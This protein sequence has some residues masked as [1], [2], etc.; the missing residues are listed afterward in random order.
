MPLINQC[1]T[2]WSHDVRKIIFKNVPWDFC[3]LLLCVF[4]S[5][6]FSQ[7]SQGSWFLT[8]SG[9]QPTEGKREKKFYQPKLLPA[10]VNHRSCVMGTHT[11]AGWLRSLT[12]P[13]ATTTTTGSQAESRVSHNDLLNLENCSRH[14]LT[15][16]FHYLASWLPLQTLSDFLL[17]DR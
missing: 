1:V 15:P 5:S 9:M 11:S 17:V 14:K 4:L 3:G 6:Q 16:V 7:L 13:A 8:I 2:K 12:L 10:P